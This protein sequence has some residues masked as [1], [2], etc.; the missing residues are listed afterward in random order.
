MTSQG[1]RCATL[2]LLL[3]ALLPRTVAGAQETVDVSARLLTPF[4]GS[5]ER[6]DNTYTCNDEGSPSVA[7]KT[8]TQVRRSP[9]L[10]T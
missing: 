1:R 4:Y 6:S 8:C 5:W 3:V 2:S 7:G 9:T 10:R